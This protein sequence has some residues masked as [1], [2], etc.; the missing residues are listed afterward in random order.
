MTLSSIGQ[1]SDEVHEYGNVSGAITIDLSFSAVKFN[2][3]GNVTVSFINAPQSGVNRPTAFYITR[4]TAS[5]AEVTWPAN[6]AWTTP[7]APSLA[8]GQTTIASIATINGGTSF[9]GFANAQVYEITASGLAT[10]FNPSDY[11]GTP[12]ALS[13]GNKTIEWT[14]TKAAAY[15]TARCFGGKSAGKWRIAIRCDSIP[16]GSSSYAGIFQ[17]G[18]A[19]GALL[20][21]TAVGSSLTSYSLWIQK[22]AAFIEVKYNNSVTS[23]Y[24]AWTPAVND[25]YGVL[26]DLDNDKLWFTRNGTVLSGGNPESGTTPDY[27]INSSPTYFPAVTLYEATSAE[28]GIWTLLNEVQDPYAANWPSFQNWTV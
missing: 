4:D 14:G 27:S 5:A 7:I 13:N 19:D 10:T 16:V 17:L 25:V 15:R 8:D 9:F 28:S 3:T 1:L 11:Y 6:V 18:I 21:S 2:C 23:S 24:T 26:A 22:T 20:L 12:L